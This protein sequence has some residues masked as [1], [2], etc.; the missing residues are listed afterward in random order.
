MQPGEN[1]SSRA[2]PPLKCALAAA[3]RGRSPAEL[4][5]LVRARV[6]CENAVVRTLQG[7]ELRGGQKSGS[8]EKSEPEAGEMPQFASK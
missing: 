2:T 4:L 1:Q 7:L 3:R 5:G 6:E 8:E